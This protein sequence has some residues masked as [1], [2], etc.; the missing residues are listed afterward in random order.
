MSSR[1]EFSAKLSV[2]RVVAINLFSV[3]ACA[4]A[5]TPL[6]LNSVRDRCSPCR[7]FVALQMGPLKWFAPTKTLTWA[8]FCG[9]TLA[10]GITVH[11]SLYWINK[12]HGHT[13]AEHTTVAFHQPQENQTDKQNMQ[14]SSARKH[15][16]LTRPQENE[17]VTC[18]VYGS[19][20]S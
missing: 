17:K 13:S 12:I 6:L 9:V 1:K 14:E 20:F 19:R 18:D 5:L 2:L 4:T 15:Q 7:P 10:F 11:C 8:S 16:R 3:R